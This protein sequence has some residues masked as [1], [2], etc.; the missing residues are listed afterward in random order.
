MDLQTRELPLGAL[1][2]TGARE[3][4]THHGPQLPAGPYQWQQHVALDAREATLRPF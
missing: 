4:R 1:M 2:C 3:P